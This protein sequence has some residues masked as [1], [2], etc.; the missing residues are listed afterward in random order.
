MDVKG[1]MRLAYQSAQQSPDPSNQ[2]GAVLVGPGGQVIQTAFNRYPRGFKPRAEHLE[3]PRKYNFIVHAEQGAVLGVDAR[4]C[5]LVCP[6]A[7]CTKCAQ[8]IVESGVASV[9]THYD[10]MQFTP[11]RWI[12]DIKDANTILE[13]A[14]VYMDEIIGP[15]DLKFTI[16]VNGEDWTC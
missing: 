12:D 1:L 14:G 8:C 15:L 9:I 4:D 11:E 2:N 3:R 13:S 16:K 7:S 5:I 6:W 10:R